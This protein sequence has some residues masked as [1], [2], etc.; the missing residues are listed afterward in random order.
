MRALAIPRPALAAALCVAVGAVGSA[1]VRVERRADGSLAMVNDARALPRP[2]AVSVRDRRELDELIETHARSQSLDPDLV[3][4][5][6]AVES[7][8]DPTARSRKGAMGLM[9]LM[10]ATAQSLDVADPY[11]PEENLR[12]G[13][14]YLRRMLDRFGGDLELALAGYNAGPEAVDRYNGLPPYPETHGYVDRVLRRFRGEGLPPGAAA[15]AGP[16]PGRRTYLSR[17]ANGRLV[18]TTSR[19]TGS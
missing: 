13:T 7:S 3:R 11:D 2:A 9:Q 12:G 16:R 8:Y 5:V 17:D 19:P 4:A 6:V 1:E 14:A 18:L 15:V 10:P